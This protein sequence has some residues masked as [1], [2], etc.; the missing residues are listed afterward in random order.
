MRCFTHIAKELNGARG[1]Q[2]EVFPGEEKI[3]RKIHLRCNHKWFLTT[4][5][6][7]GHPIRTP[8]PDGEYTLEFPPK[9]VN[10]CA[11]IIDPDPGN[12]GGVE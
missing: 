6:D 2:F 1:W 7:E 8:M 4:F 9:S 11:V 5:D 12:P 10:L 3:K